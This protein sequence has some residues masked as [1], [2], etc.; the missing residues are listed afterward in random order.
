MLL[1]AFGAELTQN[2]LVD[3][4]VGSQVDLLCIYVH[5]ELFITV[6]D[7]ARIVQRVLCWIIDGAQTC[8]A[9][10]PSKQTSFIV[11]SE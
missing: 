9:T 7:Y 5:C 3:T 11:G 1:A 6:A 8:S 10:R 4:K 2:V